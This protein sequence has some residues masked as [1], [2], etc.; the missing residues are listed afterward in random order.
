MSTHKIDNP[1]KFRENI[2]S[3]LTEIIITKKGAITW[4]RVFIIIP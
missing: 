2:K 3:K 4:K 1:V